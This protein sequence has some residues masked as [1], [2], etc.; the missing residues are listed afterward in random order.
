MPGTAAGA[1]K[2]KVAART[3]DPNPS[4]LISHT[5]AGAHTTSPTPTQ[6]MIE[7]LRR[8]AL[9]RRDLISGD[10]LGRQL[11]EGPARQPTAYCRHP[12]ILCPTRCS[13]SCLY[14]PAQRL[15]SR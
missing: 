4:V 14:P 15:R 11:A 2:P 9:G 8:G 3:A 10:R 5:Q 7:T 1:S 6:I 12:L 13:G